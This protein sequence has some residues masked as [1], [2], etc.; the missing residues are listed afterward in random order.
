MMTDT[1]KKAS[2]LVKELRDFA[3][4]YRR[5][6][7]EQVDFFRKAEVLEAEKNNV[8]GSRLNKLVKSVIINNNIKFYFKD[9]QWALLRFS[10]T[11]PVMRIA[12]EMDSKSASL[13]MIA[14]IKKIVKELFT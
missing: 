5:T 13:K 6:Y 8:I 14:T 1:N 9:G 10:G 12:A 2:E 11:E 7:D 3:G 4:F